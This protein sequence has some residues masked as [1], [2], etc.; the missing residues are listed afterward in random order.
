[1]LFQS[2]GGEN[3]KIQNANKHK[4]G[5]REG[6]REA[7]TEAKGEAGSMQGPQCGT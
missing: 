2:W 5:Q 4:K 6:G 7:E 3:Y 1:M